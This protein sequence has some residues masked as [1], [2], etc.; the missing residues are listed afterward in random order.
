MNRIRGSR[1]TFLAVIVLI[2]LVLVACQDCNQC[3]N[4][5]W[6]LCPMCAPFFG[7]PIFCPLCIIFAYKPCWNIFCDRFPG[8]DDSEPSSA[9]CTDNPNECAVSSEYYQAAIQFCEDYPEE[10]QEAFDSWVE[11]LD[12]EAIE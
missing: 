5:C 9:D 10:C 7:H 11:S 8:C 3:E 2:P 6:E 1:L 4:F 12:E